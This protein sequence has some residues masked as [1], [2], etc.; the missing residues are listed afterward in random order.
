MGFLDGTDQ[1]VD[2]SGIMLPWH[3]EECVIQEWNAVAHKLKFRA[4][5][6]KGSR[7]ASRKRLSQIIRANAE[8]LGGSKRTSMDVLTLRFCEHFIE[9]CRYLLTTAEVGPTGIE[10]LGSHYPLTM[11][12]WVWFRPD[13]KP[14]VHLSGLSL[15]EEDALADLEEDKQRRLAKAA[16]IKRLASHW[17][18]VEKKASYLLRLSETIDML[19][20]VVVEALCRVEEEIEFLAEGQ[21]R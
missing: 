1:W 17:K 8:L 7:Y 9:A 3:Y 6:D 10:I 12:L 19:E 16:A 4:Y 21:Q 5:V 2:D 15:G 11:S 20:P 13:I 14:I 18:E